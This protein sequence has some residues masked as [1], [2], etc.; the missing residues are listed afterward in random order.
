MKRLLLIILA[1]I[2]LTS[3]VNTAGGEQTE[4]ETICGDYTYV[5]LEN[6]TVSIISYNRDDY[7]IVE[8]PETLDGHSVAIIG[9][10]SFEQKRRLNEVII[11]EGVITVEKN[12]F[13]YCASLKNVALPSSV[14]S[15]GE[16]AFSCCRNLEA[17]D[18]PDGVT[19]IEQ[20]TFNQCESL[21]R[22]SIPDSVTYIGDHAFSGC[23]FSRIEIPAGITAI[24]E[25]VFFGCKNLISISIPK[26]VTA[27][28]ENAFWFCTSLTEVVIP[29]SVTSI[30]ERAFGWCESLTEIYIPDSVAVIGDECFLN[31]EALALIRLPYGIEELGNDVF[32][33]TAYA[34][35]I[36]EMVP[37]SFDNAEDYR[38]REWTFPDGKKVYTSSTVFY[39]G[40][41]K[42]I[43]TLEGVNADYRLVKNVTTRSRNDYSGWAHDTTTDLYLCGKDGTVALLCSITH[44]PPSA[45]RVK[46]GQSLGGREAADEEIWEII[47]RFFLKDTMTD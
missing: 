16:S 6:G 23:K 3:T 41:P 35:I 43:R 29:E 33:N 4:T 40:L 45:G 46:I 7:G 13:A 26:G 39:S 11:P 2:I 20:Y 42:N 5:L 47:S 36:D 9:A 31:C 28:G 18:I 19:R 17:I 22:I 27:I 30:G 24:S 21:D 25:K 37:V 34:Q 12:A 1:L 32:R 44:S 38:N 15:I 10:G 8:I 14:R